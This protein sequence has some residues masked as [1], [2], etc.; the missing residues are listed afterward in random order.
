MTT[1][2]TSRFRLNK[3]DFRTSPWS[4]QINEN[5]DMLDDLLYRVMQA[6]SVVLFENNLEVDI[7]QIVFDVISA[8]LWINNTTHTTIAEG[9]FADER[10]ANPDYWGGLQL[11]ISPKGQWQRDTFY[12]VDDLAYDA[13]EG[14]SGICIAPHTSSSTGSMR[15]DAANWVF[16]VDSGGG[17]GIPATGVSFDD[18]GLIITGTNVQ[19]G[20]EALDA[21]LDDVTNDLITA[22][23]D[24]TTL[25]DAV[26]AV[27][28]G[29]ADNSEDF[30]VK[31]ASTGLS[32]ER[33]VTDGTFISWDWSVAGIVKAVLVDAAITFA[34]IATAAVATATEFCAKTASKLLSADTLWDAASVVNLGN[35][36][37][38]V[39]IDFATGLNFKMTLVGNVTLANPS[40][41]KS[42]QAFGLLMV[43]DGTGTRTISVGSQWFVLGGSAPTYNTAATKRNYISGQRVDTSVIVYSGAKIE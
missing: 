16:M 17:G 22:Q 29:K 37:G 42:G 27:G 23:D 31:T 28:T 5:A 2:Y 13:S 40:N 38:T 33:V 3:P 6:N 41:L 20:L 14:L 21:G 11:G 1:T 12:A 19:E 8:T 36:S 35:V 10:G 30:L 4:A 24:I 43:Q 15:D 26:A 39:T 34:K 25:T 18:T 32:A 7:G 9:T